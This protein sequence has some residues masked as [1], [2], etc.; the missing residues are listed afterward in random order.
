MPNR[1]VYQIKREA[2]GRV[3]PEGRVLYLVYVPYLGMIYVICVTERMQLRLFSRLNPC[4]SA[5]APF[6]NERDERAASGR[7]L[8]GRD[9]PATYDGS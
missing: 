8:L 4:T 6:F 5:C 2:R 3:A 7:E 9:Q 1:Y